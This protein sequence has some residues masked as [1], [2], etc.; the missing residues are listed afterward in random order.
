MSLPTTRTGHNREPERV[1]L[2]VPVKA[3]AK[4]RAYTRDMRTR[5]HCQ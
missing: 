1:C 3:P 5:K 4:A 2:A